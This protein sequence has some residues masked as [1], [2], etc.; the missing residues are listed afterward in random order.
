MKRAVLMA[1]LVGFALAGQGIAQPAATIENLREKSAITDQDGQ[2]IHSWVTSMVNAMITNTDPDRRG[3]VAARD[4]II[5]EGRK[6][7]R[8]P[9]FFQVFGDKAI[10]ALKDG[11][12]KAVSQ[13]ARVSLVMAVAELR[14]VEGLPILRAA[15]EKD[16]YP[17]VRYGAA[18]GLSMAADAVLEKNT[19]RLEGDIADSIGKVIDTE[20][21]PVTLYYLFETLGRFDHDKAHDVLADAIGKL[22][23]RANLSDPMVSQIL[24]GS[25][26]SLERAWAREV[27]PEAKSRI[28]SAFATICALAMAP[29]KDPYPL[30]VSLNASLEKITGEKVGF[31]ATDDSVMQK[32]A[33]LEW[34]E[35]FVKEK[36]IPKRPSLPPAVEEALKE[37][38]AGGAATP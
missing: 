9:A 2:Q 20:T 15:L 34:V 7:G 17:A 28:L 36:K 29:T 30:F 19:P 3:M 13:D 5:N 1:V 10:A 23:A 21:S 37:G 18:K 25:V 12:K 11:E 26:Q 6:E 22:V 38:A 16:P 4:A 35:K 14:R 32:L 8:S 27:R 24:E 31:V 33:L